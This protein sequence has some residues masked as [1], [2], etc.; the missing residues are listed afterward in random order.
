MKTI[1]TG[2]LAI[3]LIA[4]SVNGEETYDL[5]ILNG[6]VMDP[7]TELDAVRNVGMYR[8]PPSSGWKNSR[9]MTAR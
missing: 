8:H 5:V 2:V 7:E 6:H 3:F 4:C 1:L 9:L